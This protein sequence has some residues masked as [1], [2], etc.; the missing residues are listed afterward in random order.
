[1]ECVIWGATPLGRYAAGRLKHEGVRIRPSAFVDN[2]AELQGIV[3]DGIEVISYEELKKKAQREKIAILLALKNAR[4]IFQV[5]AQT[6]NDPFDRLGII[7]PGIIQMGGFVEP[8]QEEGE[9]IWRAWGE[10]RYRVIPRVEVNL[11]DAC[12]LKCKACTHFSSI[13]QKGSVYSLEE[14]KK[15]LFRL[16]QIGQ[17]VRVRLDR[18]SVV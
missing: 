17:I 11:I 6:E 4:N 2:N 9:V 14:Y 13:F 1:M 10:K 5:F 12:N 7:K 18:K 16:R 15:D 3:V 8:W